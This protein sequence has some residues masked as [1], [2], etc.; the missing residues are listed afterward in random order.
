MMKKLFL[1]SIAVLSVQLLQAQG[2][3]FSQFYNA[4]LLLN[5]AN[6]GLL[7]DDDYR[8]GTQYRT[9]FSTVPVPYRTNNVYGDF[10]INRNKN[11]NGWLGVGFGLWDDKAGDG[12]LRLTKTQLS[13]AYHVITN[14]Y[15][16]WSVGLGGAYVTRSINFSNLTFLNQWDEFSFNNDLPN[17]ENVRV[18]NVSY[19]DANVGA[20]YLYGK[21]DRFNITVAGSVLH[22]N[23]PRESFLVGGTNR[24]GMRPV[25]NVEANFK[26]GENL[27][28][29]PSVYYTSQKRASELLFGTMTTTNLSRK[30]YMNNDRNELL[31]GAYHR[32]S[33]ALIV[34]GGYNFNNF[35]FM[36]S[37]DYTI[38]KLASA[39]SGYGALEFSLGYVARY[40]RS[41]SDRR[42]YGCPRF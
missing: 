4:P 16:M 3:H 13:L 22:V 40:G 32:L 24:L 11:E 5:P 27:I 15:S 17:Q 10:G 9:Q 6:S 39:N 20:K 1:V 35:R 34:A 36:C 41:A 18:G 29:S 37:Y 21:D 38:S 42:T 30:R 31:I 8:I 26:S 25:L 28:F 33:D 12:N 14:D 2:L 7:P 19:I 23:Q